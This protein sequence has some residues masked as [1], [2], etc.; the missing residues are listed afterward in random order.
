MADFF[1]L[2]TQRVFLRHLLIYLFLYFIATWGLLIDVR[3]RRRH[4]T[5]FKQHCRNTVVFKTPK[6]MVIILGWYL[7]D[8]KEAEG[9][10]MEGFVL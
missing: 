5:L 7:T 6:M 9:S 3:C 4:Y 10:D 1:Y 2:G 8:L